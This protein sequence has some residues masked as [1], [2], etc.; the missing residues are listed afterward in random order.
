MATLPAQLPQIRGW[1]HGWNF[2]DRPIAYDYG[3]SALFASRA[4]LQEYLPHPAHQELVVGA[5]EV[6]DWVVCD[7]EIPD[8]QPGNQP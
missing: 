3:L 8:Q 7:Y 6:F 5:R 2:T 1:E 4:D